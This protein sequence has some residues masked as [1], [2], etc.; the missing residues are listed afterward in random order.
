MSI[1]LNL[2]ILPRVS[3]IKILYHL[4]FIDKSGYYINNHKL[5]IHS[6]FPD[7]LAIIDPEW[8][9]SGSTWRSGSIQLS[10]SEIF[11]LAKMIEIKKFKKIKEEIKEETKILNQILK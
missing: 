3:V 7:Q 4:I 10:K 11:I 6:T 1:L 5:W 9:S 2:L 8:K